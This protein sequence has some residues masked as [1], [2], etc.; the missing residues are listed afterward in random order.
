VCGERKFW[1][2][3]HDLVGIGNPASRQ[4]VHSRHLGDPP[5]EYGHPSEVQ[6]WILC[7]AMTL[8]HHLI[9]A[10]VLGY[11]IFLA[12]VG[13]KLGLPTTKLDQSND[14][15]TVRGVVRD[16]YRLSWKVKVCFPPSD[17]CYKC[18]DS[19]GT[20]VLC[21]NREFH[22]KCIAHLRQCPYC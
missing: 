21:C 12:Y 6:S 5:F 13:Q 10:D 15:E 9:T 8:I 7:A 1:V 22:S 18:K 11:D 3:P 2:T 14:F 19:S 17:L 4:C 20:T 16:Q